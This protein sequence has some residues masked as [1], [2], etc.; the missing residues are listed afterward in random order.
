MIA[1][2]FWSEYG[3][4][5]L[6]QNSS[7]MCNHNVAVTACMMFK[8]EI[9]EKLSPSPACRYTLATEDSSSLVELQLVLNE[10]LS[11]PML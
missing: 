2:L 8:V 1:C 5:P 11:F 6:L 3:I 7:N 4:F 9:Q 10:I